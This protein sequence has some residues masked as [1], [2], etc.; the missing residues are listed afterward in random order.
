MNSRIRFILPAVLF[1]LVPHGA[2]AQRAGL[3]VALPSA[4]PDSVFSVKSFG[5]KGDGRANDTAPIQAALNAAANYFQKTKT[6]GTVSLPPGGY[7]VTP[8]RLPDGSRAFSIFT[9]ASGVAV[10]GSGGAYSDGKTSVTATQPARLIVGDNAGD[11]N[12][13]FASDQNKNGNRDLDG[14]A[15]G[16]PSRTRVVQV[17]FRD[18]CIEQDPARNRAATIEEKPTDGFQFAILLKNFDGVAVERMKF[19]PSPGKNIVHLAGTGCSNASVLNSYFQ[20]VNGNANGR[21]YDNSAV[22]IEAKNQTV[23]ANTFVAALKEGAR[24][25]IEAHSG[26][27]TVENNFSDGYMT[28][29]NVTSTSPVNNENDED[30]NP[31]GFDNAITVRNNRFSRTSNAIQLW[32]FS[33]GDVRRRLSNVRIENNVIEMAPKLQLTAR[34]DSERVVS[35]V[36][37]I[38]FV[39]GADNA[40]AASTRDGDFENISVI[41]NTITYPAETDA[42]ITS[43]ASSAAI[44]MDPRGSLKNIRIE[45]NRIERAPF[46]AL[47][48]GGGDNPGAPATQTSISVSRN[49]IIDAGYST[50]FPDRPGYRTTIRAYGQLKNVRIDGNHIVDRAATPR[51]LSVFRKDFEPNSDVS[52]AGNRIDLNG[53]YATRETA[54][55]TIIGPRR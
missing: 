12:S 6:P 50:L 44:R 38:C 15:E 24:G 20:F 51:S 10:Q 27:A 45:G 48:I 4:P 5:A 28:G 52:F 54:K 30:R 35:S 23:R 34:Q 49:E 36:V 53:A 29:I 13:V 14:R 40:R 47:L 3:P 11:Y 16:A 46:G 32:S 21:D 55:G 17:A 25:A 22:Y 26:P 18:F 8:P 9:V 33:R 31:N 37:A 2:F 43:P 19:A 7:V 1:A 41:G 39:R 42:P